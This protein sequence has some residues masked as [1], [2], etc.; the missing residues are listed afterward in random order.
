MVY[1]LMTLKLQAGRANNM[2]PAQQSSVFSQGGPRTTASKPPG[3]SRGRE[4]HRLVKSAD[5]QAHPET[6][7][8]KNP[9]GWDWGICLFN[10]LQSRGHVCVCV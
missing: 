1:I 3:V 8:S 10:E 4:K 5:G 9:W 2:L 7:E 6:T